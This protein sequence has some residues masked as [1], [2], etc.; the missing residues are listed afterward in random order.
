MFYQVRFHFSS[1]VRVVGRPGIRGTGEAE[2]AN[3][4]FVEC[5]SRGL[6]RGVCKHRQQNLH[7]SRAQHLIALS[8]IWTLQDNVCVTLAKR[9][10]DNFQITAGPAISII[11]QD[12]FE[13]G[14][15][16]SGGIG[17][18]GCFRFGYE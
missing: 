7:A 16:I 10:V 4:I 15:K 6:Y 11:V 5:D 12:E 1:R 3:R 13:R 14:P 18:M 2:I 17:G 9:D 8:R